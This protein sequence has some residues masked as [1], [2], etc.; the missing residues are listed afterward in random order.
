MK[1]VKIPDSADCSIPFYLSVEEWVARNLPDDEYFF[2]W[3]VPPSVICGRHQDIPCEV[4]LSDANALGVRVWRRKSGGGAV[5]ADW[6]NVMFSYIVH[7]SGVQTSFNS[8]TS[9]ICAMLASLGIQAQPT[10]RNDIAVGGRKVAGNAFY[11]IPGRSIVHG[12]ML[13]DADFATMGRVLTPSRAKIE[14]KGVKS[15]PS[16]VTTLRA[17][18]LEMSCADFISYTLNFLGDG[19]VVSLTPDNLMEVREIMKS[20]TDHEFLNF[21]SKTTKRNIAEYID[22]VGMLTFSY[23][24][25]S[26]GRIRCPSLNGDFFPLA[27][28]KAKITDRIDG[29]HPSDLSKAIE[30]INVPSVI[31][32]LS[33]NQLKKFLTQDIS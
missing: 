8:Y 19:G 21:D 1:H 15:V 18:G 6:N 3:Q 29:I 27:D 7:S 9:K 5:Y 10:G 33:N 32:G 23:T 16:R 20:Y 14:S 25:D 30:M 4:S 13:Y 26:E 2:A 17:E 22:G 31:S 11:G 24:I 12:T 28:V